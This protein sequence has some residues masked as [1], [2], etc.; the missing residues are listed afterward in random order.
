MGDIYKVNSD[1]IV[2]GPGRL[3]FKPYDGTY[4]DTISDVMDTASPYSLEDGWQDLGATNDGIATSRSFDTEEFEV[5]QVVGA[6][7]TDITSWEHT[8]ETNLA[9]N[10]VENRKLALIGGTII[11]SSPV[12]GTS[13]SLTGDI[14]LNAT[15]LKV[16][17]GSGFAEG[18]FIGI[19]EE[20]KSE[21][22]KIARINGNTIYLTSPLENAFT[23]TAT[24]SPITELGYK[25][26]GYGTVQDVPFHTFALISQKKDGS[27]YMCVIR[28][29]KVSGE[30]KEQTYSKEKRL[31]PLQLSAF[32]VDNVAQEENVYYEIE[33]I[34]STTSFP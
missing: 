25:R 9:E 22:K 30:D 24:V 26:I 16:A 4:P 12:L 6:V 15:I 31:L 21:T 7:D 27:L 18:G 13:T 20:S 23:T 34:V 1:R 8:L 32:P 5:D 14:A 33:Q 3:V 19:T 2:G 17:S 11:E 28:K 29:A 10:T